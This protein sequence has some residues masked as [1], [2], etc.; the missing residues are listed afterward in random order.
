MWPICLDAI[1]DAISSG[2]SEDSDDAGSDHLQYSY[3]M[4]LTAP[5]RTEVWQTILSGKF[6]CTN[7]NCSCEC[8]DK[9]DC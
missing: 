2:N 7:S 3:E 8:E 4:S 5:G 1:R 9:Q 6:D